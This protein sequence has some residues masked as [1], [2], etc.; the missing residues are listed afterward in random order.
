MLHYIRLDRK[1]E[2]FVKYGKALDFS[3]KFIYNYIM[4]AL[5]AFVCAGNADMRLS[6][7]ETGGFLWVFFRD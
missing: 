4:E 5:E 7:H 2:S 1:S 3:G 6:I